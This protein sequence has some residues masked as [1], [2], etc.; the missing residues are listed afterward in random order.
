MRNVFPFQT[1]RISLENKTFCKELFAWIELG[2]ELFGPLHELFK[3]SIR[4]KFVTN[5]PLQWNTELYIQTYL[6]LIELC[7]KGIRISS[8]GLLI[9]K[10]PSHLRHP[11]VQLLQFIR[12]LFV[13]VDSLLRLR[14]TSF[15]DC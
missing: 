14:L 2:S 9:L 15:D 6:A 5:L 4:T 8:R 1:K 11:L 10:E 7:F 13:L 3:N 12:K